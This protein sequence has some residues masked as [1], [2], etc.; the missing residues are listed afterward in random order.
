MT[1]MRKNYV[2][3]FA[4]FGLVIVIASM[5]TIPGLLPSLNTGK[6]LDFHFNNLALYGE[7]RL[8]AYDF[9]GNGNNGTVKGATFKKNVGRNGAYEFDGVDD[10]ITVKD[11]D[12]LSPSTTGAFTIAYWAKFGRTKF[13]GEGSGKNY[14]NYLG[15]GVYG[16]NPSNEFHFRQHNGSNT[17]GRNNRISFYVFNPEGGLGAGSY[18]QE[19][20]NT[21]Q[22]VFIVG[23]YNGTHVQIWKNGVLKD[24]DPLSSYNIIM[25][26]GRAPL[27]LGGYSIDGYQDK[28]WKGSLDEVR[29]YNRILTPQEIKDIYNSEVS[30]FK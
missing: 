11:S 2:G 26:N 18:F 19:P 16:S 10:L 8:L 4:L 13:V 12:S 14:I 9:S 7:N 22:W 21:N 6:V 17:E 29:I 23:V 20:I 15:K 5:T 28:Y 30:S 24:T 25:K 3:I 1:T 27:T